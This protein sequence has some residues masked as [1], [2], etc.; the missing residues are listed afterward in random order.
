MNIEIKSLSKTFGEKI[1]FDKLDMV[2]PE[3]KVTAVLSPSGRG[4]TTL[5]RIITEL[6]K[7]Y[8]GEI[9]GLPD[10]ISVLFQED[11]LFPH[12]NAVDNVLAC[13]SPDVTRQ[14]VTDIFDKLGLENIPS[15][16]ITVLSGG[17][18][19][20]VSLA[21]ALLADCSMLI[22]DEPF[23]GLDDANRRRVAS[24]VLEYANGRTVMLF[25]HEKNEGELLLAEEFRYL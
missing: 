2:I 23:K 5:L 17:M 9:T 14:D 6:D 1:I 12:L 25:A 19:R 24:T 7:D 21:R 16:P 13:S 20:R 10:K 18:K 8:T 15:E 11:R 4:K 3:G 22:L